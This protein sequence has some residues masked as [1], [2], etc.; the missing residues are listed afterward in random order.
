MLL[1]GHTLL[2]RA[3]IHLDHFWLLSNVCLHH[4]GS[5]AYSLASALDIEVIHSKNS[6]LIFLVKTT[7]Q[8]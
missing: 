1:F 8:I 3:L 7:S 2:H 6:R 5:L 4:S